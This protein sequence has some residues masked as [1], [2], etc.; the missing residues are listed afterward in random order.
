MT[1]TSAHEY[2][3]WTWDL[4]QAFGIHTGEVD[5]IW[6]RRRMQLYINL[7]LAS[8]GQPTCPGEWDADF[9]ATARSLLQS[10]R[11]KSRL[12]SG[13]LCPPDR[14]IQDFLER[15]LVDLDLPQVPGLP[16]TTIVLDRHGV[17]RE[18]SLPLGKDELESDI[19]SSYRVRQGI[20]HN[21]ASDRRT[22]KGSFHVAEGG[23][24]IPGDK[25][26]VPKI[27]F[28]RLLEAAL[29]PPDEL[30]RLPFT[31]AQDEPAEIFTSLLLR[32][33]VCPAVPGRR[34]R[35][36]HGDPLLRAGQSGEQPGLRREHL[37]QCR[38]PLPGRERRRPRCRPLDRPHRLRH[39]RA[40][41]RPADQE[42]SSACRQWPRP[43]NASAATACAGGRGR[44]LQ[45]RQRLQDHRRDASGVIV[46][47][48]RRQL[49]RLLQEGGEDPDQLRRQPLRPCRGRARRRRARLPAYDLGEEFGV[50]S[51][52][53][54]PGYNFDDMVDALWRRSW[55]S[56]RGLRRRQAVPARRLRA[57]GRCA[58]T[59]TPR[60]SAG[61]ETARHRPSSC[62]PTRIYMQP[63]GY[64]VEMQKHP[65]APSLAPGRHRAPKALSA[66]S[67]APSPAAA[68]PRFPSPST[69][70]SSPVR[71]SSAT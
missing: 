24:P 39:P 14:R 64:K 29:N 31:A 6:G 51:R 47:L 50:D 11:E 28:A 46:T 4:D 59:S 56:A 8:S 37:R 10:Y 49:L 40:A 12:L 20:L 17:A 27:A 25:K 42:A 15:Y 36:T 9:L 7:K 55:T 5:E 41:S 23:L 54:T 44:A 58:W 48:H 65:G 34:R 45:R 13:Y 2:P 43:P 70:P 63:N 18:L 19:I 52:T 66:T 22:T 16:I 69:T 21:P 33:L 67:P 53:R 26:A 3:D 62:G 71:C 32:P 35:E 61:T 60:P 68:S 38:R 57:A 30:L 1:T